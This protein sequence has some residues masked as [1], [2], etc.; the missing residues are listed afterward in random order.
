MLIKVCGMRHPDN[1]KA[2]AGLQPDYLGFIFYPPSPRYVGEMLLPE[3]LEQI[4][5]GIK[6]TGVFVNAGTSDML[7]V[8]RRYQ[9][10]ALQL[11]GRESAAQCR[12][13]KAE[14]L[15]IIKAFAARQ[16]SD[17]ANTRDYEGNCD[18]FLFDTPSQAHGGSGQKY[19]WHLLQDYRGAAPFFL[20]G[21]LGPTDAEALRAFH[22]PQLAGIDLNSR[23][24]SAPAHKDV[25]ALQAFLNKYRQSNPPL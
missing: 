10:D 3:M 9:L 5:A 24:E 1:I 11:H 22:H 4:P 15:E 17:F 21:G 19:D 12:Q 6:K 18:Y 13:L 20:S 2:V 23:F 8:A 16:G 7:H 25:P 14:G